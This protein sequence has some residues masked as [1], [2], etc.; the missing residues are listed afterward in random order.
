MKAANDNGAWEYVFTAC[1]N[2]FVRRRRDQW[3]EAYCEEGYIRFFPNK[4]EAM[5]KAK[6]LNE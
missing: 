5:N 3:Y 1:R 4:Q 2:W 6:E